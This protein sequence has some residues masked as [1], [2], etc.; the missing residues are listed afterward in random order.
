MKY[1]IPICFL[2]VT[3]NFIS[4]AQEYD[5]PVNPEYDTTCYTKYT[6]RLVIGLFQASQNYT[7]EITQ[8]DFSDPG[9]KS[10]INY[11]A[12]AKSVNGFVLNYDKLNL[13]LAY[14]TL[15]QL[16]S[17][18][19]GKTNSGGIGLN[20]GGDKWRLESSYRYYNGFY[21]RSTGLYDSTYKDDKPYY[22]NAS[23]NVNSFKLK[24][25]YFVKHKK[26]SYQSAYACNERQLKSALSPVLVGNFY[27]KNLTADSSFIPHFIRPFYG[28]NADINGLRTVAY[29]IG[30]GF[31]GTLVIYKRFFLSGMFVLGLESQHNNYH[32]YH[33]NTT[34]A[35]T[36]INWTGDFRVAFGFNNRNFFAIINYINDFSTFNSA[37]FNMTTQ[38]NSTSLT[39]GYRF[40]VTDPRFMSNIRRTKIYQLF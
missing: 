35:S 2:L 22:Q 4:F 14:K 25:M 19:K 11:N 26:F 9:G 17:Y 7:N 34:N 39:I 16:D 20:F 18:K 12:E 10:H 29:S 33:T 5:L 36:Y 23:M 31:S 30:G 28:Y 6:D 3:G 15:P 8:K 32:H 38:V 21:D 27:I 37:M 24:F 1:I 13:S 40:K